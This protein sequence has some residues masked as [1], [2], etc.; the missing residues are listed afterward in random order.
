MACM[1]YGPHWVSTVKCAI[2]CLHEGP[3]EAHHTRITC[4]N[5]NLYLKEHIDVRDAQSKE[6]IKNLIKQNSI[7]VNTFF[8]LCITV[9]AVLLALTHSDDIFQM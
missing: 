9:H 4:T 8:L 6:Y 5:Y 2:K 7:I 1:A 3:V